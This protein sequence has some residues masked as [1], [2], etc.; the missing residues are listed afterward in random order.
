MMRA[1]MKRLTDVSF[2]SF[3]DAKL[4]EYLTEL[5]LPPLP[6]FLNLLTYDPSLFIVKGERDSLR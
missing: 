3:D 4:K 6:V 1:S 5:R 2:L